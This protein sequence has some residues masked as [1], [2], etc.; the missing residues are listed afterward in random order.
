[1][2]RALATMLMQPGPGALVAGLAA[3]VAIAAG[4]R[5]GTRRRI[6]PAE[7]EAL[8]RAHISRVGRVIAGMVTDVPDRT[9]IVYEY[10][11]RGVYYT[12][13]QEVETLLEHVPE[14]PWALLG[15]VSVRFDPQNPAN[16]IVICEN[17]SG[18]RKRE[19]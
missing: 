11:V 17:W 14:E 1:M 19:E 18:L 2:Q 7:V 13:T 8:R 12:T 4:I 9:S 10:N 15:P 3:A 5:F 6:T 16:S